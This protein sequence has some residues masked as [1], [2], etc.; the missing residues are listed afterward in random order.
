MPSVS[1]YDMSLLCRQKENVDP[2]QNDDLTPR[3]TAEGDVIPFS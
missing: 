1:K 3:V 2:T